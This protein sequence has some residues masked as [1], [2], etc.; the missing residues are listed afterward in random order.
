MA[1]TSKT[2]LPKGSSR[3]CSVKLRYPLRGCL[4]SGR[5]YS[6]LYIRALVH[7]RGVLVPES[8]WFVHKS[9]VR[10]MPVFLCMTFNTKGTVW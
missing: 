7:V 8:V 5:G 4:I 10:F 6:Q 9:I 1:E 3:F 2:K